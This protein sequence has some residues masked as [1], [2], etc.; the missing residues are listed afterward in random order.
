MRTLLL[1]LSFL[2]AFLTGSHADTKL[3][4]G[5]MFQMNVSGA[6]KEYTS[7][8]DLTYTVD[9]GSINVPNVG[10]VKVVGLT[11]TQLSM[12][13]EKRL[14]DEKIFTNPTVVINVAQTTRTITV[15]GAVR[16]PGRH[17]WSANMTLT[18]AIA[19]ASGPADFAQDKVRVVRAG[20]SQEFSRKLLRKDPTQ[21]PKILPGDY[22]ELLGD[23]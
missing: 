19:T 14:R 21:D 20:Q 3:G 4:D 17:P 5:D 13:I 10:R 6:P 23:F 9:D 8:Y 2:L 1:C 11:A 12:A 22:V 16:N 18:I 15:G 7:E